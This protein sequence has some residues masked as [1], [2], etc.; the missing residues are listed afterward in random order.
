M[1]KLF[2][3][4]LLF[5]FIVVNLNVFAEE[6]Y[7][8]PDWGIDRAYDYNL[9]YSFLLPDGSTRKYVA[10]NSTG[11]YGI[12]QHPDGYEIFMN[13]SG[14]LH[15]LWKVDQSVTNFDVVSYD[16]NGETIS[17]YDQSFRVEYSNYIFFDR[18]GKQYNP[19]TVMSPD[20]GPFVNYYIT[21]N[22][23]LLSHSDWNKILEIE[24][25]F[26]QNLNMQFFVHTFGQKQSN[27]VQ[28]MERLGNLKSPSGRGSFTLIIYK[29]PDLNNWR[30]GIG[31]SSYFYQMFPMEDH[32]ILTWDFFGSIPQAD[33]FRGDDLSRFFDHVYNHFVDHADDRVWHAPYRGFQTIFDKPDYFK[34]NYFY[35][36]GTTGYTLKNEKLSSET[37]NVTIGVTSFDDTYSDPPI[38]DFFGVVDDFTP[39]WFWDLGGEMPGQTPT[40]PTSTPTPTRTPGPAYTPNFVTGTPAPYIPGGGEIAQINPGAADQLKKSISGKLPVTRLKQSFERLTQL[41]NADYETLAPK[42]SVNFSKWYAVSENRFNAPKGFFE[43]KETVLVDFAVLG[44]HKFA[45][46]KVIEYFR[47][48]ITAALVYMTAMSIYNRFIPDKPLE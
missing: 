36:R 35:N 30:V 41:S 42:I 18:D 14:Q 16:R 3:F 34:F 25:K 27:E 15:G 12:A 13:G 40:T 2:V 38:G 37:V 22:A 24:K 47:A 43:D 33:N 21:D 9:V 19:P 48:L 6:P 26:E 23:N 29:Q 8:R 45:G 44:E 10:L 39:T 31:L 11:P 1:K 28:L 46:V 20:M 4:V 17:T 32:S 7:V 5:V